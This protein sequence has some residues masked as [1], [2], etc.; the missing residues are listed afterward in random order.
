MKQKHLILW[1]FINL[2]PFVCLSKII[3]IAS[4]GAQMANK[5]IIKMAPSTQDY[6]DNDYSNKETHANKTGLRLNDSF[7]CDCNTSKT[8]SRVT[9]EV[10]EPDRF[11]RIGYE[12]PEMF[13]RQIV[14][15]FLPNSPAT[16][17]FNLGYDAVMLDPREDEMFYIIENDLTRKYVI[18]G[19]GSYDVSYEF[20][21]G[22]KIGK[23]G[24]H[25]IILDGIENFED[26]IYIK[27]NL[28]NKS[29]N[30][31][32]SNFSLNLPPGDYLNRFSIV[33]G[34]PTSKSTLDNADTIAKKNLRVYYSNNKIVIN[35]KN[36]LELSDVSIFNTVG[37]KI[38]DLNKTDL[39]QQKTKI[40]FMYQ[41]GLYVVKVESGQNKKTFK[42]IN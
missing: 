24:I 26:D 32:E 6:F 14:L 20:P 10:D 30:L 4:F 9:S 1:S 34:N 41:Q 42:I 19:V 33:F 39:R 27:D 5:G 13:Y 36:N 12:D 23:E 40:P 18:Q 35:N 25:T 7:I 31:S 37:Q 17:D 22:L 8:K 11:I 29:Y 2:V 28:L 16:L 15:G 21:I 3:P 38:I